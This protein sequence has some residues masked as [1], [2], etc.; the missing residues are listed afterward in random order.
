MLVLEAALAEVTWE[1]PLIAVTKLDM[2]LQGGE[3]CACHVTERTFDMIHMLTNMV[4]QQ[5]LVGKCFVTMSTCERIFRFCLP[6]NM[7]KELGITG[8]H[9]AAGGTGDQPLLRMT[10]QMFPQTVLDF[11]ERITA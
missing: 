6:L 4:S 5:P 3:R 11:K 2:D 8:K 7:V 9:T 1:G 10:A